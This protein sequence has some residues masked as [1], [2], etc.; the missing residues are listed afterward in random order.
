MPLFFA[1][2]Y[3]CLVWLTVFLF[4]ML[5]VTPKFNQK[6][7]NLFRIILHKIINEMV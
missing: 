5:A 7:L 6:Q 1:G 3:A 2:T 4:N